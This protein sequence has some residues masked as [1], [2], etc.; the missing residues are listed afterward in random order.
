MGKLF[1]MFDP[2]RLALMDAFVSHRDL[3]QLL[4]LCIDD[5]S[6]Q[7]AI[8]HGLSN[9]RFNRMNIAEARELVGYAPEDD[10]TE[11]N[12]RTA[13]LDLRGEVQPHSQSK[14]RPSGIR[15]EL[16]DKEGN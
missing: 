16:N 14:G 8:L 3:N 7:F 15:E 5:E 11:E 1:D 9:N 10:F 12:P 4:D 2:E 6:L 13:P